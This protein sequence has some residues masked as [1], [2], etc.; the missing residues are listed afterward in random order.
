[1]RLAR[2]ALAGAPRGD[3]A[4]CARHVGYLPVD[5]GRPRSSAPSACAGLRSRVR[6]GSRR[7]PLHRLRRRSSAAD[8]AR[9]RGAGAGG[10]AGRRCRPGS[11][12]PRR[13]LLAI[14]CSQ[15]AWP[16][17]TG[18]RLLLVAP[19][20]AAAPRLL[21]RHPRGAPHRGRGPDAA[22]LARGDR[23]PARGAR[24]PHLA[25]RDEHLAF[26]LLTD[27]RDAPAESMPGDE[28]L[29]A[30]R[31]RE[32]SRRSTPGTRAPAAATCSSCCIARAAGTRA[33]ACGWAGSASAA[34]SR[35]STRPCAAAPTASPRSSATRAAADV[36][37]VITL[38][39]DTQLPRDAARQ[40]VGTMAHPLNRP[41]HDE[42][43]R[44]GHPRPR[45]PAAAR[46]DHDGEQR[47]LAVRPP[48][49]RRDGH[50]PVHPRGLRR[51]P[52]PVRRGLVRRQ[53]H[54]RRRRVPAGPRRRCPRTASSATTC[55]RARTPAPAWSATSA[56]RG[57]PV[58]VRGRRQPP[59]PLAARRLA[60]RRVAA[61]GGYPRAATAGRVR[62]PISA[63]SQWKLL[64][65][66]RRSLVP[67]ALLG[68]A[69]A[70]L[71]HRRAWP[72]GDAAGARD[73][74]GARAAR[75]G[76]TDLVRRP[77]E[78][79]RASTSARSRAPWPASSRARRSRWR[80]CRTTRC[81]A[82]ARSSARS[83]AR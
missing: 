9:H 6:R 62:N 34:S 35:S 13:S 26:A 70:R 15:L 74:G 22:D 66:L 68:A 58:R 8:L 69:R 14:A 19:A 56:V 36:K 40:L 7:H 65:N 80:P 59:D 43:A 83:A 1:V 60:D 63:L 33:R 79:P 77:D 61:A 73:P 57:L 53:G 41:C 47:P 75:R 71:V 20:R 16:S 78:L 54:L 76:R 50:R 24:G 38:D 49:R 82:L 46:G 64:D 17:C 48:V 31:G 23:R 29:L 5:A 45:D 32:G 67:P 37:Y 42:R 12:S 51:V 81:L 44:P 28:A 72:A 18:R 30:A 3:A 55:S 11:S 4:A 39:S 21:G 52:G 27:F 2:A 25:N 10:L